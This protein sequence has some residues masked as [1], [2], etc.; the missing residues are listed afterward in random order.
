MPDGRVQRIDED[1]ELIYIVRRGRI[2]AAPLSEVEP[3]ARIPS[4]RVPFDLVRT[5][6]SERAANIQLRT[7]TRTNKR[8][9]RFADLT[10]A[11]QPGAKVATIADRALG[12][13]VTT[14]PVRVARA[15]LAALGDDDPD[16]ATSLYLPGARLHVLRGT[17]V[18]RR[19]IRAE[20]EIEP[21]PGIDADGA[22]IGGSDRFVRIDFQSDTGAHT[23]YVEVDQG[24][25]VEQWLDV[26]PPVDAPPESE[27]ATVL[28]SRG[29]VPE[30]AGGYASEKLAGVAERAGQPVRFTRV[31]L[32]GA[33][34][35]RVERPAMVELT[36]ELD[37]GELLRAHRAATSFTEATDLAIDRLARKLTTSKGGLGRRLF[38]SLNDDS[39]LMAEIL[40][41]DTTESLLEQMQ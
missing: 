27:N 16:G 1:S 35:P 39:K 18:G 24:T 13:D 36:V 41:G 40:K 7:G 29:E 21:G 12:V 8:Q 11:H 33:E 25:I 9:R 34:N 2:Y 10:G 26:S 5:G 38:K 15:W 14:Q 23:S 30:T 17:L 31:K 28:V 37:N 20:L 4:V 32:T 19:E 22:E 6:G 3:A